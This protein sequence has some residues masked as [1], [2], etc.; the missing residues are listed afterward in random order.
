[1]S[2]RPGAPSTKPVSGPRT[3]PP[4]NPGGSKHGTSYCGNSSSTSS[5]GG[6]SS[7]S[8]SSSKGSSK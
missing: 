5:G 2:G 1:M 4:C 7:S 3:V 6:S 8:S